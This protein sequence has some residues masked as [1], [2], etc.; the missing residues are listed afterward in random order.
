MTFKYAYR[1][2]NYAYRKM[3]PFIYDN[4]CF[5]FNWNI[6]FKING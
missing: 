3:L 2:F 1:K 4:E 5:Q 6:L